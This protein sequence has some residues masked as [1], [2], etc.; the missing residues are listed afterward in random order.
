MLGC[1]LT[2]K[3]IFFSL[4]LVLALPLFSQEDATTPSP[5]IPVVVDGDEVNYNAEARRIEAKGSVRIVYKGTKVFCE[6]A[7]VDTQTNIGRLMGDVKIEHE[8]G[9]IFGDSIVY[10]FLNKTAQINKMHL[11]ADPFYA[12]GENV[13]KVSE[14]EYHLN[15]GYVTTCDLEEPH[16]R[17]TAKKILFYPGRKVVAKNVWIKVGKIP[18]F[19]IPY[20]V[21][22]SKD[23]LPR[24]TLVPG[25]NDDTGLYMLSAWRYYFNEE[26]KGRLHLDYYEEKGFGGGITHK[27]N[28]QNFGDGVLKLYYVGD[29]DK[30]SFDGRPTGSDRYKAQFRHN[31]QASPDVNATLE[32]HKFSD[33]DFMKDYFYREYERDTMPESYLLVNY[34]LRDASFSL[35]A[36]KRVND[37]WSQ[38]EYL[39]QARLDV[40]RR[41]LGDT[42]LYFDSDY[43]IANLTFKTASPSTIDSDVFRADSYNN[44]SY[45]KR[46]GWLNFEPYAGVRNTYYTKNIFGNEDILRTVFYSGAQLSTKLYKQFDRPFNILGLQ[47]D[48]TR[49]IITPAINYTYIHR[50]TVSQGV[51]Q[52]FDSLDSIARQNSVSFTLYNKLQAK[53]NEKTWDLLYFAPSVSY[54]VEQEARGS[55]FHELNCDFEFRPSDHL[56]FENDTRYDLD[57]GFL[58]EMV[59]DVV[60]KD[61][62]YRLSVGHRYVRDESSQITGSLRY[63]LTPKW[64]F[65]AYSRFEAET[66]KWEEQQYFFRRDLHC[67]FADFGVDLN[68]DNG[69]TFWVI[70]RIK[71]FP[72]VGIKFR[73]TYHGPDEGEK[74]EE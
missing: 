51:L 62:L 37:F 11:T 15:Q 53:N 66:G 61:E 22:P 19:Y 20:F 52:Q 32:F 25:R 69:V 18:I 6:Q 67:W 30:E 3:I 38:V 26:F 59:S 70:F 68:E 73:K 31:W 64:E 57:N 4:F 39:P 60:L 33:I 41:Q 14:G 55:Y 71:A 24:V 56:Y 28:T 21:Q 7:S 43:S 5:E 35:F 48:T 36:Q 27:Y 49:H 17:M 10:D 29:K 44:L 8:D 42:N 45:Q 72:D 47:A 34:A 16:Y 74:E 63:T 12:F 9:V 65:R 46:L 23:K 54:L 50:P 2:R 1:N 40:F 13:Q 58:E